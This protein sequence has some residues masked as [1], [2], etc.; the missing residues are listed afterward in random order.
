MKKLI[1]IITT[2]IVIIL[3]SIGSHLYWLSSFN[4]SEVFQEDTYLDNSDHKTALIIVAHDDDA[5]GCAGTIVELAKKGWKIHFL[6]FYGKWKAEENPIRKKEV[7]QVAIIQQLASTS[8]IDFSLQKTDTVEAPWMPIPYS[9][10]PDYM[11][12]DSLQTIIST[13]VN[14][15]K[16]SVIFTL[17]N[18]IG[19]YGHPE[20]VCVSQSVIDVCNKM[21]TDSSFS[22][23]KI[24]QAVF[25]RTLNENTLKNNP[26]FIA[27]KKIYQQEGSPIPDVQV[28]IYN[29]SKEKKAIMVAYES[30]KRNLKKIWPYYYLY[31]HWI[32]FK[33]FDTEYFNVISLDQ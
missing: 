26:T 3:I 13:A 27:A 20:H 19:G 9:K 2:I 16:P 15:Y 22:V 14:K 23:K 28:N 17:D 4:G 5:V 11:Y 24:Y 8:L 30:Q 29:S 12:V 18:L 33:I 1:K 32:Y 10:F 7:A 21:K 6:T 31:P 25:S